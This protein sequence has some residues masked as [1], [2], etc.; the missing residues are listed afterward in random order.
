VPEQIADVG[1][2]AEIVELSGINGDSHA[3][4]IWGCRRVP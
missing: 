1:P 2:D 4:I 3:E